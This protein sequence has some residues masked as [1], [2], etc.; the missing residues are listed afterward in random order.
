MT[1]SVCV[2]VCCFYMSVS[3]SVLRQHVEDG[4]GR[5]RTGA[6]SWLFLIWARS[7]KEVVTGKEG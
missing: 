7:P 4:A 2:C 5:D 6:V 3:E 1:R